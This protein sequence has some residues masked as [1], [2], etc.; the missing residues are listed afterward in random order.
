MYHQ[1]YVKGSENAFLTCISFLCVQMSLLFQLQFITVVFVPV[2]LI[3]LLYYILSFLFP[4]QFYFLISSIYLHF[5]F[6]LSFFNPFFLAC[7]LSSVKLL[8]QI[9]VYFVFMSLIVLHCNFFGLLTYT[10]LCI[11]ILLSFFHSGFSFFTCLLYLCCLPFYS[12]NLSL[13]HCH[14]RTANRIQ[15]I[16]HTCISINTH[17]HTH[18]HHN[19]CSKL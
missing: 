7:T 2:H 5:M 13:H 4:L 8:S 16:S 14:R 1:I 10:S 18:T 3:L 9:P 17:T 19:Q 12:E 6:H 15:I 11:N